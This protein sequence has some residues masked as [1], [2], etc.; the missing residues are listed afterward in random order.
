ML[1]NLEALKVAVDAIL[2][3]QYPS[4]D[5]TPTILVSN[6]ASRRLREAQL[7]THLSSVQQTCTAL[8]SLIEKLQTVQAALVARTHAIQTCTAPVSGLPTELLQQIFL[9]YAA[10]DI[11]FKHM[12]LSHVSA[13]WREASIAL[14]ELWTEVQIPKYRFDKISEEMS[15]RSGTLPLRLTI[16]RSSSRQPYP[17]ST[18]PSQQVID[19]LADLTILNPT[20]EQMR[21]IFYWPSTSGPIHLKYL[22]IGAGI[23]NLGIAWPSTVSTTNLDLLG[24][25][26]SESRLL[27]ISPQAGFNHIERFRLSSTNH[28]TISKALIWVASTNVDL[29]LLED[30]ASGQSERMEWTLGSPI[31]LSRVFHLELEHCAVDFCLD[32]LHNYTAP[33]L[34]SFTIWTRHWNNPQIK[35]SYISGLNLFVRCIFTHYLQARDANGGFKLRLSP[36]LETLSLSVP[37]NLLAES[38]SILGALDDEMEGAYLIPR[39]RHFQLRLANRSCSERD[40][41]SILHTRELLRAGVWSRSS[42]LEHL[43][44]SR[45]LIDKEDEGWFRHHVSSL[46]IYDE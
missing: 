22:R 36:N 44:V 45:D 43:G 31:R 25:L 4:V 21:P 9:I 37:H 8:G 42:T 18:Q 20:Y 16:L 38:C 27:R 46:V 17:S 28:W 19:R 26:P 1:L 6:L 33:I 35:D 40:G 5:V 10:R 13:R 7:D 41:K 32:L 30:A 34:K 11:Y 14:P 39:L 23:M 15:V 2:A 29:L 24:T 3:S 12:T